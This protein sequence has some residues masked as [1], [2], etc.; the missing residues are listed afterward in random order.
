[1]SAERNESEQPALEVAV[2]EYLENGSSESKEVVLA[3]G[4]EL[5]NYYASLY[6]PGIVD[7]TLKEAARKGYLMALKRYDSSKGVSFSYY[8]SHCIINQ[9][10]EVLRA[11]D[12]FKVPGWLKNLQDDVLNATEELSLKKAYLPS[13]EDI[14]AKA[15]IAEQGITEAMQAGTVPMQ[16][17]NISAI[18]S[19]RLETLK[20]P[21]EDVITIRKSIDR[22]TDIQKKFLSLISENIREL[23]LAIKEEESALTEAQAKHMRIA[24]DCSDPEQFT[25]LASSYV[26][27]FPY[28]YNEEEIKRYFEVLSDEFGLCLLKVKCIGKPEQDGERYVKIPLDIQFD[29]RYRGILQL[30]DYLRNSEKAVRVG[31]VNI[32]RSE[33]IPARISASVIVNTYYDENV[34]N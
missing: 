9:I 13:L 5:S 23:K 8:A 26:I 20:M 33:K 31:R 15:N 22:L 27:A 14:A 25:E 34:A 1:M 19:L 3:L 7:V 2:Q 17:I 4:R 11:R 28:R 24:E 10:R 16:E 6:S 29:G 21:I 30:L 18:K 12:L 32:T